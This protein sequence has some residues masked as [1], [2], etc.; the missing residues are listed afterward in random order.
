M[1]RIAPNKLFFIKPEAWTDIYCDKPFGFRYGKIFYG[2]FRR[3]LV[4]QVGHDDHARICRVVIF[5]FWTS[6]IKGYK[7]KLRMYVD[8]LIEQLG[9]L[10]KNKACNRRF[11]MVG[12]DKI[13]VNIIH[14]LNF[15]TFDIIV[16]FV[17]GGEHFS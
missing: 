2:I 17:Y 6:A 9:V 4:F 12:Q 5:A 3:N 8:L 10:T 7:K 14:W 11:D 15:T 13:M 16:N 1:I